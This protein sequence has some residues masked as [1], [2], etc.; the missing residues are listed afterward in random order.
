MASGYAGL[1]FLIQPREIAAALSVRER[2]EQRVAR[3]GAHASHAAGTL[4]AGELR[5]DFVACSVCEKKPRGRSEP[6][7]KLGEIRPLLI[8]CRS[9]ERA[10]HHFVLAHKDPAALTFGRMQPTWGRKGPGTCYPSTLFGRLLT[11]LGAYSRSRR[12][13]CCRN[14]AGP[15]G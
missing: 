11:W 1:R 10:L 13:K 5:F 3:S 4:G 15:Q 12:C 6:P 8:L 7:R 14:A 9:T 2:R